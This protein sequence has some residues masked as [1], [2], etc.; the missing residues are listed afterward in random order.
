MTGNARST[1]YRRGHIA[2]SLCAFYLRLTGWRILER[3]RKGGRGTGAGEIYISARRG[4]T[5]AFI[6]VKARAD[7]TAAIEA[8]TPAQRGRIVRAA[9]AYLQHR[10]HLADCDIRFDVMA[11]G[12]GVWPR[13]I[14]DAWR[15]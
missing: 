6:E 5:L 9:E 10:P 4:R 8:V 15:P 2:E 7:L 1:A 14:Q 3:R 12:A 11:L 13:H